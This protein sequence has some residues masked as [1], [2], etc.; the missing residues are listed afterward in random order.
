MRKI[1]L[2]PFLL[3]VSSC[4]YAQEGQI[5]L[6]KIFKVLNYSM[7]SI[8]FHPNNSEF[9]FGQTTNPVIKIW[10]MDMRDP[11]EITKIFGYVG[12]TMGM[13]DI[14]YSPD[15]KFIVGTSNDRI[16]IHDDGGVFVVNTETIELVYKIPEVAWFVSVSRGQK[17][18][19]GGNRYG[20]HF[21]DFDNGELVRTVQD[22]GDP[23]VFP[24]EPDAAVFSPTKDEL[25]FSAEYAVLRVIDIDNDFA[26]T[27]SMKGYYGKIKVSKD[28]SRLAIK[29][30]SFEEGKKVGIAIFNTYTWEE[31][32]VIN[33]DPAKIHDFLIT[34]N[35]DYL[36]TV[37][38]HGGQ[39]KVWDLTSGEIEKQ[40]YHP[41][42]K[43]LVEIS[44]N[45]K[46]LIVANT[47]GWFEVYETNFG[48]TGFDLFENEKIED[49]IYPNPV[50][51]EININIA[52]T[53][54]YPDIVNIYNLT[55]ELVKSYQN[56]PYIQ[57]AITL[58]VHEIES[59]EYFLVTKNEFE[60]KVYKVIIQK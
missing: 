16:S 55:G 26:I 34:P 8:D 41:A 30:Y 45:G 35:S 31:I 21:W 5:E 15:G 20:I 36:V 37:N 38:G 56:L 1:I 32:M 54:R 22:Y 60:R 50:I 29:K 46:Y 48:P 14:E 4:L 10:D 18:I 17:Y 24:P 43:D 7:A 25:Y 40:I 12:G 49:V 6:K 53:E 2:I 58:P 33:D 39:I 13:Y 27:K 9:A 59:G 42:T 19:C 28:G 51:N 3:I 11:S 47:A 52:D 57:G 23:G 44:D